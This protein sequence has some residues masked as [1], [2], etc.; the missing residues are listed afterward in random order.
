VHRIVF[1]GVVGVTPD[2]IALVSGNRAAGDGALVKGPNA[3]NNVIA[4][5]AIRNPG[6]IA[7]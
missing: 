3:A 1:N 5:V 2:S 6:I 4:Y 7:N